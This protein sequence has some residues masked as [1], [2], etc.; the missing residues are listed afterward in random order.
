MY[1]LPYFCKTPEEKQQYVGARAPVA[2][3]R[4]ITF[5]P[6]VQDRQLPASVS[7]KQLNKIKFKDFA[8]YFAIAS[9]FD[10]RSDACLNPVRNQDQV[11][12]KL[13]V[14]VSFSWRKILFQVRKLLGIRGYCFPG[15]QQM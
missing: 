14:W 3:D 7:W 11:S 2:A 13:S 10:Y 9:Q 6:V 4:E 15:V 5:T 12:S 1:T 8:T